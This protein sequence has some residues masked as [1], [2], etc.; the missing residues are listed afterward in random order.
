MGCSPPLLS[1]EASHLVQHTR[2]GSKKQNRGL[3]RFSG[4]TA[5][6]PSHAWSLPASRITRVSIIIRELHLPL[7]LVDFRLRQGTTSTIAEPEFPKR[8][9][10]LTSK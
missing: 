4:F 10:I 3:R 2:R 9:E 1:E 5:C 7:P 6:S 8:S